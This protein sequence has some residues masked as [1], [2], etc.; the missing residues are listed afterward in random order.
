MNF[1]TTLFVAFRR[2]IFDGIDDDDEY[3][4]TDHLVHNNDDDNY[5]DSDVESSNFVDYCR[6]SKNI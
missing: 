4:D 6:E 2:V 1:F 3:A 5:E